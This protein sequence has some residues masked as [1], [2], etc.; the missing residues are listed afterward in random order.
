MS[1][2]CVRVV[3]FCHKIKVSL[4]NTKQRL[5]VGYQPL[6]KVILLLIKKKTQSTSA[7][8]WMTVSDDHI[9]C[10]TFFSFLSLLH[11]WVLAQNVG[12]KVAYAALATMA[13]G[14]LALLCL[15]PRCP[16]LLQL[17]QREMLL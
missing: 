11:F 2:S 6:V 14:A 4:P 8:N 7:L 5:K 10:G 3:L 17:P 16:V 12:S 13:V 15:P 1:F 9:S